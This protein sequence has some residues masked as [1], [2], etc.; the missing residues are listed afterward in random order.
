MRVFCTIFLIGCKL[1]FNTSYV[2]HLQKYV[3]NHFKGFS[4]KKLFDILLKTT[5]FLKP[6][7][8]SSQYSNKV[9]IFESSTIVYTLWSNWPCFHSGPPLMFGM[10]AW[11]CSDRV[12]VLGESEFNEFWAQ[13][14]GGR[15]CIIFHLMECKCTF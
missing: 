9:R 1:L 10:L 3:N 14:L 13:F 5:Y 8:E 12:M 15:K 7:R 11:N 6:F 2:Y 4:S